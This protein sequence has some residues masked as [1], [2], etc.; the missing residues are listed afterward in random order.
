MEKS[1]FAI[2]CVAALAT[3][4]NSQPDHLQA[5]L[6]NYATIEVGSNFVDGISENGSQ[7]LNYFKSAA[8]EVDKIYWDQSFADKSLL[9]SLSNPVQKSLALIN[10]GPW[11]RLDGTPFVDGYSD[12]PLGANFYPADMTDEE[13]KAFDD[14]DKMSPYTLI[15]RGEDGKLKTVWYHDAY[16]TSIDKICNYLKA[17]ADYTIK[18]SVRT[19]LLAKIDALRTDNYYQSDLAWLDMDDSKMDL[20]IGPN[21]TNDDRLYG[22]KASYEAFV[23]LKDLRITGQLEDYAEMIPSIQAG[24]P[25]PDEYKTFTPGGQSNIFAYDAIYYA[26]NANAGV[27]VIAVNL[28]YDTA[29]QAE[30]GTRTAIL[31]NVIKA[32]FNKIVL[33]AGKLLLTPGQADNLDENAFFWNVA[34]REVSHGIGVKE[35][36]NGKGSVSEALGNEALTFEEIKGDVLGV[37]TTCELVKNG[38]MNPLVSRE[39]ALT[40]FIIGVIRSSRFGGA[41]ALGRA[42]IICYN[43]LKEA[44]AFSI[45]KDGEYQIDYDKACEVIG[46]LASFVLTTQATGDF[47]GASKFSAQYSKMPDS[48]LQDFAAFRRAGIPIDVRFQFVW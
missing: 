47:A 4:C 22:I 24:L 9:D 42:N 26:G 11:D 8:D 13:F 31:N 6:D 25:C 12:R 32:K 3:A 48:L 23:L 5:K 28:P 27:K 19:Y 44:G 33:P 17:A 1:L 18:P 29:V 46:S 30:K 38:Q 41:D 43:Y 10:Y 2:V 16:K 39:D 20:V 14:P 37:Y 45:N 35:T 15:R 40:T 34:F 36:V 21:E 7:V